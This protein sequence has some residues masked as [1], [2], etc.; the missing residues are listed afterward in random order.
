MARTLTPQSLNLAGMSSLLVV[1]PSSLGDVVHT[2]P[3][4]ALTQSR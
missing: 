4:V 1:K 3:A 2:L